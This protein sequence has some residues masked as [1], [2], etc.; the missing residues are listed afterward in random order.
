M[1]EPRSCTMEYQ[2]GDKCRQY[3]EC[4]PGSDGTCSLVTS[5]AFDTCRSCVKSCSQMA[6]S[7]PVSAFDCEAKC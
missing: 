6:K 7:D 1:S 5:P 4:V 3:A 2:L